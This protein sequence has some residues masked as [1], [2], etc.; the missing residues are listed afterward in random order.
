[1][2]TQVLVARESAGAGWVL[3]AGEP[4]RDLAPAGIS[5][6]GHWQRRLPEWLSGDGAASIQAVVLLTGAVEAEEYPATLSLLPCP[7]VAM[8]PLLGLAA[9]A[10]PEWTRFAVADGEDGGRC[11]LAIRTRANRFCYAES[12]GSGGTR[13]ARA[14]G[15][16][17]AVLSGEAADRRFSQVRRVGGGWAAA[18][19]A[20]LAASALHAHGVCRRASGNGPVLRLACGDSIAYEVIHTAA[21]AF[22]PREDTLA[23][24][25][26]GRPVWLAVD[27]NV[28]K[29]YGREIRGY[30]AARLAC[31]GISEVVP[32]DR[33]KVWSQVAGLCGDAQRGG[34]PRNGIIAG[35]GGGVT[36]DIAGLAASLYH[37]GIGYLRVPTTL[38]GM[39]DVA[40]GI[41][42]GVNHD[43]RKNLLGAFYP[44][45]AAV[46]DLRFLRTLPHAELANGFAEII[47]VG[48][49][50]DR[51]LFEWLEEYGPE[52]LR[53]GFQEPA[54]WAARIALRSEYVLM[55]DLQPNLFESD[56]RR[57]PDF[58]HTFSMAIEEA[59]GY[60]VP[61]G[62]AV[63]ADILLA[64]II[65][66]RRG[67]CGEDV[68]CRLVRLYRAVGLL[69]VP[70]ACNAELLAE[71]LEHAR[72]RRGGHLHM[73]L[74]A[75]LG[76]GCF[77]EDVNAGEAR[78]ALA[79]AR[80][81]CRRRE[82]CCAG[83]GD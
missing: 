25:A 67:L 13:S 83:A 31:R 12:A 70:D 11:G 57:M 34:L 62:Q 54:A 77:A 27:A 17:R 50:R 16:E 82:A 3:S 20:R 66:A 39:V 56:L 22:D 9:F 2:E 68:L 21:A 65:A 60:S 15:F 14:F 42:Q 63:A 51:L 64:T 76:R 37:R 41:K 74:P 28:L 69:A 5:P 40:V 30:A 36:M 71:A 61:H 4:G 81:F 32:G 26:A 53:S 18:G 6:P 80:E 78:C 29:L 23:A 55:A 10:P 52:L 73:V 7:V 59:S 58:G 48:M 46:N 44:H 33:A 35:V 1:M 79:E 19:A 43:G 47:K 8:P 75:G 45:I 49:V 72:R 24:I 38:L